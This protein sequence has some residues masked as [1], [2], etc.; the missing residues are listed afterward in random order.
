LG[1]PMWVFGYGS[2][3]WDHWEQRFRGKRLD[4][5]ALVGF[6]RSFNKASTLNWG[7]SALPGP[8]LGLEQDPDA[9]EIGVAFEF[10]ASVTA[11][12]TGALTSREGNSFALEPHC[13]RLPSGHQSV[14]ALVPVNSRRV[15]SYIGALT[16][17]ERA[18]M[19]AAAR[20][21]SGRC[22]DYAL[23]LQSHLHSHGIVDEHVNE[24]VTKVI[25]LSASDQC[26]Q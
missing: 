25:E 1:Q 20:G 16:L 11:A 2:L 26:P 23:N 22:A 17:E 15:K 4:G 6:H 10:S 9:V 3:M 5:A 24:F 21:K 14:S 19:A 13:V 7:T 18:R 12:V 8:T